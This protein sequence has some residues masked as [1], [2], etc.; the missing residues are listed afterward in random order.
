MRAHGVA[1][2]VVMPLV[3]G[4]MLWSVQPSAAVD[5]YIRGATAICQNDCGKGDVGLQV[6]RLHGNVQG[7][8][9]HVRRLELDGAFE[10]RRQ[11]VHGLPFPG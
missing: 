10:Q 4:A 11:P 5:C 1:A 8:T 2:I 9:S 7:G 6:E 3:I